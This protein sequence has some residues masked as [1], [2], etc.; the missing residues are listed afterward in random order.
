MRVA[1]GGRVR[2]IALAGLVAA[3]APAAAVALDS[4][5]TE[6][7]DLAYVKKQIAAASAPPAFT[8]PGPAFDASAAK[9]KKIFLIP[10]T[11]AVPFLKIIDDSIKSIGKRVGVTVTEYPNQG[12]PSQWVQG[13]NQAIA[14]KSDAIILGAPPEQLQPQL[15]RAKAAGIP[16][17]VMH[18]YDKSMPRPKNVSATAFAPFTRA[19]RLEADWAILDTKGKANVVI[20]NSNEVPPS[21]YIV[22]AMQS[23]FK[24]RCPSCKTTVINVPA[25][26]WGTKM[27]SA[28]QSALLDNPQTNYV[29]PLYDSAAQ[30]VV[31]G[32]LAAG[33]SGKVKVASY[34]GTPFVL[35]MIQDDKGVSM[36]VA[37]S[38]D[39]IAYAHMDQALR[40]L[41]GHKPLA[42]VE[43]PIRAFSKANVN[44]AGRP[45]KADTGFGKS[46]VAG[47][48]KLWSGGS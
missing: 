25:A 18:L 15:A 46:Y 48:A 11:S 33:R 35:K 1:I 40:L 5:A 22:S 44:Q 6:G 21:R 47:Y 4:H 30:F 19:A 3:L 12:Q 36:D 41:T 23:E 31:P 7:A 39:W 13:M 9:G 20:V 24:A 14:E 8:A 29:I 26:D 16:V 27:Q 34:N 42:S 32:I 43:T 17:V 45:P 28:V 38:L 2:V 10:Q 37:E